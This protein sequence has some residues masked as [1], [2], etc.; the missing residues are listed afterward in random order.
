MKYFMP[1]LASIVT[2]GE[3]LMLVFLFFIWKAG[4][5]TVD[6]G[7][8]NL[9]YGVALGYHSAFMIVIGYYFGSSQS[10]ADKTKIMAQSAEAPPGEVKP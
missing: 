1:I 4:A 10:S 5:S 7:V 6:Q 8:I 2:A 3:I 9:I